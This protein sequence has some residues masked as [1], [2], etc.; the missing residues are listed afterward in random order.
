[1]PRAILYI[2]IPIAFVFGIIWFRDR[3]YERHSAHERACR[4][5]KW[6]YRSH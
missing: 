4:E 2:F 6:M 3:R 5:H 1:M